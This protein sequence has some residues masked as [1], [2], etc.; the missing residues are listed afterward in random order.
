V[1]IRLSDGGTYVFDIALCNEVTP[2]ECKRIINKAN[3]EVK[4]KKAKALNWGSLEYTGEI[5]SK[6][7]TVST[8]KSFHLYHLVNLTPP[9]AENVKHAYP[10]SSKKKKNWDQLASQVDEDKLEGEQ[11]LNKVFQDIY[12]N[13]SEEQRRAMMKSFVSPALSWSKEKKKNLT[14]FYL[15]RLNQAA[16]FCL[17][18][19]RM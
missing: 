18:T 5:S 19:G 15:S 11:A 8:G 13:G 16:P 12:G 4:L 6:A 7:N 9:P 14:L 1:S 17:P 10:S 3:V 2:S